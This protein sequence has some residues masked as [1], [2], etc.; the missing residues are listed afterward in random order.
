M[1][2]IKRT[3]K[4]VIPFSTVLHMY[5]IYSRRST[6]CSEAGKREIKR[7]MEEKNDMW[8]ELHPDSDTMAS[9]FPSLFLSYSPC[10][11]FLKSVV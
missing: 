6:I 1:Y 3:S 4:L 9:G 2:L 11:L 8:Y 7:T 10:V 5:P